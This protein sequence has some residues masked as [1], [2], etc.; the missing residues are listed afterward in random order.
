MCA[1][2]LK[3]AA[4]RFAVDYRRIGHRARGVIAF[5][6][7]SYRKL[8]ATCRSVAGDAP[9]L[10]GGALWLL[11]WPGGREA[12]DLA[13]SVHGSTSGL[14][15]KLFHLLTVYLVRSL[16]P[17]SGERPRA[18]M[19]AGV[20]V[21]VCALGQWM[22]GVFTL[23]WFDVASASPPRCSRCLFLRRSAALVL[24]GQPSR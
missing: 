13:E 2:C 17:P 5:R 11:Q 20:C 22:W 4:S 23:C 16:L 10:P 3:F 6:A 9:S 19:I 18:H 21:R 24:L 15:K 8:G 14:A 1:R 12:I 7:R